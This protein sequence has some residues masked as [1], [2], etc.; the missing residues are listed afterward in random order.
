MFGC[1]QCKRISWGLLE[2]SSVWLFP[3]QRFAGAGAFICH[4]VFF[5]PW[6]RFTTFQNQML[7]LKM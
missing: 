3:M 2:N 4:D 7:F 1:F 6:V 5:V